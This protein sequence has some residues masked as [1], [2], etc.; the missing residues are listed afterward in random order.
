[1]ANDLSTPVADAFSIVIP[2]GS[3]NG[4]GNSLRINIFEGN[5]FA[6]QLSLGTNV[7]NNSTAGNIA[8][9]NGNDVLSQ[10]TDIGVGGAVANGNVMQI[11]LFSFNI[12]NPQWS[13]F[14]NFSNNTSINNVAMNNGNNSLSVG[15]AGSLFP[16]LGAPAGNGNIFQFSLFSGNI[17]NPQYSIGGNI[18]N[19]TTVTNAAINNGNYSR[20]AVTWGNVLTNLFGLVGAVAG[21]GNVFQLGFFVSNIFNPQYSFGGGNTSNNSATTNTASGNGNN[22]GSSGTGSGLSVGGTTGNGNTTQVAGGSG[23]I[24][25]DQTN[26]GINLFGSN[27]STSNNQQQTVGTT[28]VGSNNSNISGVSPVS[29]LS[30]KTTASDVQQQSVDTGTAGSNESKGTGTQPSSAGSNESTSTGSHPSTGSTVISNTTT[31]GSTS[32]SFAPKVV[33]ATS[34][35]SS[36]STNDKGTAGPA[37]SNA[38]GG[39]GGGGA[40]GSSGGGS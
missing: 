27:G 22:S 35:P 19:N 26:V 14:G 1:M 2:V 12:F 36:T 25:N 21:N 7:S 34:T 40:G 37:G 30:T 18:S 16:F 32:L 38:G 24:S 33:A 28:A 23:N 39:T 20:A 9:G 3:T 13:L 29:L 31:S 17:F 10:N 4:V 6:P 15:S 5:I 11:N 8:I